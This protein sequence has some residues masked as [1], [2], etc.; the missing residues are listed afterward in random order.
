MDRSFLSQPKVIEA[1]RG[2]VAIRLMTYEDKEEGALLKA[3]VPTGSGELENTDFA[4]L[5]PDGK[6]KLVR[7]GRSAREAFGDAAHMA[8]AM[9][10]IAASYRAKRQAGDET[11]SLPVIANVRLAIDVAACDNRPLVVIFAADSLTQDRLGK[12]LRSLA[13]SDHFLGRFLYVTAARAGE[14][15]AITGMGKD[16]GIA[17][18]E[19]DR[20]GLHGKVLR[21]FG[22]TQPIEQLARVMD[23]GLA[24]FDR[25]PASFGTH[26]RTGHRQG[27]FWQTKIPVT[28]PHEQAARERGRSSN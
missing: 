3:L 15:K 26:V 13:W 2:F 22:A 21:W 9:N 11:P 7:P 5:S 14:L 16:P 23:E 24:Q 8:A 1:A 18:V 27:I 19:S 6:R 28:D 10:R 25:Q 12:Q 4:I 17:I 20:F